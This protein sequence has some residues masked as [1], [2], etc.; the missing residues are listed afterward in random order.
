MDWLTFVAK[1][2]E[3]LA[4]PGTVL[5]L[6]LIVRKELP[7]IVRSLRRLK[8]KDVELEFGE[9]AKAIATET[10]EAVPPARADSKLTGG[11]KS[12]ISA[13]LEVVA[14]LAPRAAILEAWLQ[15]EAAAADVVRKHAAVTI[16]STPGPLRL[17]DGLR[18][19]GVLNE[20]QVSVFENLRRLRNEAVHGSDVRFSKESVTSYIDSALSMAAY[21]ESI[22]GDS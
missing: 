7:G 12:D 8:F 9:A 17:L 11:A 3:A 4:W 5:A 6:L 10:K 18:R 15:V 1:V 2:V 16:S 14:D 20:R 22:A 21:L 13:R 19:A